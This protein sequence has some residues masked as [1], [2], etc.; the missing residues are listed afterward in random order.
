MFLVNKVNILNGWGEVLGVW[1]GF[2]ILLVVENEGKVERGRVDI[3]N[4]KGVLRVF[5][6]VL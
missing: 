1:E 6:F 3:K 4:W 5:L 2:I